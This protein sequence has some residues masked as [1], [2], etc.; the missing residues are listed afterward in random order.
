MIKNLHPNGRRSA[1]FTLLEVMVVLVIMAIITAVALLSL[2]LFSHARQVTIVA[3]QIVQTLKTAENE[4][5]L[6]PC[7]LGL[8]FTRQGYQFYEYRLDNSHRAHWIKLTD[9]KLS[10]P[11]VFG[12]HLLVHFIQF[13]GPKENPAIVFSSN[14]N[15]S[16]F[17]LLITDDHQERTYQLSANQNGVITLHRVNTP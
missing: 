4:A 14:G 16:P 8:R 2:H 17:V 5:L 1:A 9:D 7:V 10:Q 11:H 13:D 3:Q 12:N 6:R 15:V